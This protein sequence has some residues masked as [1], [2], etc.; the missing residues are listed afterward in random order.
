MSH[1]MVSALNTAA[2]DI[3]SCKASMLRETIDI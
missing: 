1:K 2:E 3:L